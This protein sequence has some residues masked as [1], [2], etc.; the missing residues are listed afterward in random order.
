M[1]RLT[2][3]AVTRFSPVFWVASV[4]LM[5]VDHGMDSVDRLA[6]ILVMSALAMTGTL[7]GA[8]RDA[9]DDAP[10]LLLRALLANP[11]EEPE[12]AR[13]PLRAVGGSPL[14]ASAPSN[15]SGAGSGWP[16]RA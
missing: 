16:P 1:G 14:S 9:H 3:S 6:G 8:V 2:R 10:K 5:S 11:P 12:Q 4:V 13:Y 7:C 15:P